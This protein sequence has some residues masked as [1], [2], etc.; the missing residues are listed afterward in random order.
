MGGRCEGFTREESKCEH[1]KLFLDLLKQ[2]GVCAL[3]NAHPIE[4]YNYRCLLCV[5]IPV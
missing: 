5:P 2:L 3:L 4:I 1:N